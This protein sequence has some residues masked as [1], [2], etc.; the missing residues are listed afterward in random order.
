MHVLNA[1]AQ[2]FA[3]FGRLEKNIIMLA[4]RSSN[5]HLGCIEIR[6][7]VCEEFDLTVFRKAWE[8]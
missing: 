2:V 1:N 6:V 3:C 5:S 7:Q 4:V 8:Y